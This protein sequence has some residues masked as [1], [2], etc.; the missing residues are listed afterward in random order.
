MTH[1][2]GPEASLAGKMRR[3]SPLLVTEEIAAPPEA[4]FAL[5]TDLVSASDRIC[6]IESID[7]LSEG[8]FGVG[9]R[10][11]ETRLM[12]GKRAT[13]TMWITAFEPGRSYTAEAESCGCH[14]TSVLTCEPTGE[15]E[16]ARTVVSYRFSGQPQTFVA[17]VM[18]VLMTPVS[19][20]MTRM[21]HQC[22]ADDLADLRRVAEAA[23]E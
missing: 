7:L 18:L 13:E 9:T 17:R 3:V 10:W 12:R 23:A 19:G 5:A 15:G 2:L 16:A 11:R 4:V 22:L 14:Y 21:I 8:P 20:M 6:G 1:G